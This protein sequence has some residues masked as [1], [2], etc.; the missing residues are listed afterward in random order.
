MQPVFWKRPL[1]P[2]VFPAAVVFIFVLGIG[3]GMAGGHWHSSLT[4][5]DYQQLIP[6]VPYL[7]H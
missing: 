4:N 3:V 7:S 5:A 1:A 2:W 6:L